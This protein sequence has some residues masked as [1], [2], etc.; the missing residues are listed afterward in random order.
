EARAELNR[1]IGDLLSERLDSHEEALDAYQQVLDDRPEDAEACAAVLKIGK[2][3]ELLRQRVAEILVPV[4]RRVERHQEL[5][6]VLEMRLSGEGDAETRAET[7][8]SIAEVLEGRLNRP[9]EA[10]AALLRALAEKPDAAALHADVERLSEASGS[11]EKYAD[12]LSERAQSTFEPEIG[13]DLYTRL[14]RIA[15][16]KL[17]DDQRA[18][19]AYMR[20]VEQ[21]GDQL[22][23]LTALDRLYT[24]LDKPREL[25]EVLERRVVLEA[26]PEQAEIYYRLALIQIRSFEEPSRGLAS[27]RNALERS[28]N[29]QA[30]ASE[31]E[32][33]TDQ[34]DLFEEAAELL[35]VVYR[36]QN[37][38]DR[39]AA[40]YEK[41]VGFAENLGERIEMRR[42]LARVLEEDGHDPA[43]AQRVV[44]LGLLDD[45]ADEGLLAEIERLAALTHN[46][47]GAAAALREAI[48]K[49]K[50]LLPSTAKELCVKLAGWQR[51][52][53]EDA[54][55]AERALTQALEFE[56][57][58]DEVLQLLEDLQ[59]KTGRSQQLI[60]TLRRRA[61][62]QGNPDEREQL[63]R[64]AKEL[65]QERNEKELAEAI[66]RELLAAD[67]NNT[68]ALSELTELRE[69]AG[70]FAETFKLLV[71]RAELAAEGDLIRDLR[72]R[73]AAMARDKLDD[74]DRAIELFEQLFNDDPTDAASAT[75]VRGLYQATSRWQDLA[76]LLEKLAD[77]A[78]SSVARMALRIELARLNQEQFKAPDT[79]I[80]LLRS[81]LDD[82]PGHTD[83]VVA[84]SELYEQT[85]RDAELAELLSSQ[86]AGARERSDTEAELRFQVRLGEVYESRL[87]DSARAIETYRS[88]LERDSS[89]RGA[90][91]ALARLY[92]A[93]NQD[94]EAAK[95]LDQ[96]LGM[97]EG[98]AAV[99]LAVELAERYQKLGDQDNTARALERGLTADQR[100]ADLRARLRRLYESTQSWERL[101]SLIAG[102]SEFSEEADKKVELLR[103]AAKINSEKRND[104]AAAAELLDRA[105]QIK[106][107]DRQ[108]LLDLCDEYSASGRGRAAAEVL[109]KIV[110]SYGGKRSK[111]LGDIHRRL[112]D[113]YLA[114]G[115]AQRAL[116]ELD[117]AFRIEPGNIGVLQ[118]LG[119]VALKV[120]DLKKAQQMFR[121]LLLQKLDANSPISKAEVFIR[122]ADIHEKL[123][124]K[125][126][127]IQMLERAVQSDPD[128]EEARTR[129]QQLKGK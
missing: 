10:Q 89:H 50:D 52:K 118:R 60:E 71:R 80:E 90:L 79:A 16:E 19:E 3:R 67:E 13:K 101:A 25:S 47:E 53:V 44:Q 113:A 27:L 45:P 49:R 28:P 105:S 115:D 51:D 54:A 64:Q 85:Q 29:H 4:L 72:R 38:T 70:D 73:A 34:R 107:D 56:P 39:L 22:E 14:G 62:L 82:E 87:K 48:D 12:A 84:L 20:A 41:R 5:V 128:L 83:A 102:D 74:K 57:E 91:E 100:N 121:A 36:S 122:L 119:D 15:E 59:R 24:R 88:V 1:Q 17:K 92:S 117:K 21:S 46:W 116:E 32:K 81:V 69:A 75:A 124:E 108:I 2:E 111:E 103:Q 31:L 109:E 61:K 9:L 96:L 37:R 78:E 86:I 7:L 66:L 104:H 18:V 76:S 126:K 58:D 35:E 43:A 127:A 98:E 125:P 93:E 42:N 23:L 94:A 26:E 123:D 77:S 99:R 33:L 95:I 68:W 63:Y 6:D 8:R 40:L 65:A 55:A 11:W 129:L 114:E 106:P 112:G 97:S 110:E 30:A 120:G